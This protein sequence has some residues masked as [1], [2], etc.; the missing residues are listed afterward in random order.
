M[1]QD[2]ALQEV[3][4]ERTYHIVFSTY[5]RY[6]ILLNEDYK[7]FVSDSI[8]KIAEQKGLM[9][10]TFNVLTDHVHLLIEKQIGQMLPVIIQNIKGITTYRFFQEF[11]EM[12]LDIGTSRLWN[13]G[14][15]ETLITSAQQYNNTVHYIKNNYDKYK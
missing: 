14:Y 2:V 8:N 3:H 5:K 12:K 9:I 15:N 4:L 6:P 1:K 11:S 7:H 13:R 10:K